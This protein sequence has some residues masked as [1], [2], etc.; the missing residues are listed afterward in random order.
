MN[1]KEHRTVEHVGRGLV[2]L[3]EALAGRPGF[4]PG[5]LTEAAGVEAEHLPW[6]LVHDR[7][8]M[9]SVTLGDGGMVMNVEFYLPH[10][11]ETTFTEALLQ[12][13]E[14]TSRIVGRVAKAAEGARGQ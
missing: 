4:D 8:G 2:G 12:D 14:R 10:P 1:D 3:R 9:W 5:D 6:R 13:M 11:G 7:D